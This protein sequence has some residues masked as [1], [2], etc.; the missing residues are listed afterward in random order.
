MSPR[1]IS[2]CPGPLQIVATADAI[3]VEDFTGEV[4]AWDEAGS[5]GVRIDLGRVDATG[6]DLCLQEAV[7]LDALGFEADAEGGKASKLLLAELRDRS[8]Q[9]RNQ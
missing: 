8:C 4:E 7:R 3:D 2:G 6:H 9:T 1:D 5:H